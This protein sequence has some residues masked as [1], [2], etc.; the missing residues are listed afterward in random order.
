MRLL[1]IRANLHQKTSQII[2]QVMWKLS[3]VYTKL[4]HYRPLSDGTYQKE[5][6]KQSYLELRLRTSIQLKEEL[7]KS[8]VL[9]TP[10][11]TKEFTIQTDVSTTGLGFVL[12]QKNNEGIDQPMAYGSRKLLPR[13]RNYSTIERETLA[14]VTGIKYFR[15]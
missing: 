6:L 8:P 12:M 14:I 7:S 4:L 1:R 11:W 5:Q 2:P 13:E 3:E 10:D 15:T 9:T